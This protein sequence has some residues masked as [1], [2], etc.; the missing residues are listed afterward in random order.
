MTYAAQVSYSEPTTH[1][2][3]V[4]FTE[5]E[6]DR[7]VRETIFRRALSSVDA[8]ILSLQSDDDDPLEDPYAYGREVKREVDAIEEAMYR[9]RMRAIEEVSRARRARLKSRGEE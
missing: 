7:E 1:E 9:E 3:P 6:A 4:D 5:E 8:A 2:E